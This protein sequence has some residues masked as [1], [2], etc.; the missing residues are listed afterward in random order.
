VIIDI[1]VVPR[2]LGTDANTYAH[3]EAAIALARQ[4][5]LHH[6][7]HALG[8]TIEGDPDVLWPLVRA[9][10]ESCLTSGADA[11][12]TFVKF[13][14]QTGGASQPTMDELTAKFRR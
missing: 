11:V 1:E 5:G 12:I 14:Q 13:A 7:V 9:M 2:P 10:H 6:E 8:T 3:V 4:S